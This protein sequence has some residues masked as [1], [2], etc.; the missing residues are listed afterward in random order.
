MA[1]KSVLQLNF[2]DKGT[3]C[4][5]GSSVLFEL[6]LVDNKKYTLSN[7]VDHK[8]QHFILTEWLKKHESVENEE[9][10]QNVYNEYLS[11]FKEKVENLTVDTCSLVKLPDYLKTNKTKKVKD[12]FGNVYEGYFNDEKRHGFG[13]FTK[14]D[15]YR[16]VGEWENNNKHGK[17]FMLN[18]RGESYYG[19]WVCNLPEGKGEYKYTDGSQYLG[20]FMKGE[21]EGF[22]KLTQVNG[23]IFEGFFKND[24]QDIGEVMP[25]K[26]K[27]EIDKNK[28]LLPKQKDKA[29]INPN[30]SYLIVSCG[31]GYL[32]KCSIK[33]KENVCQIRKFESKICHIAITPDQK[34]FFVSDHNRKLYKLDIRT[35][36]L[37]HQSDRK[38]ARKLLVTHDNQFLITSNPRY[39]DRNQEQNSTS[40]TKWCIKTNKKICSQSNIGKEISILSCTYDSK[41][42]LIAYIQK[43][44]SI[45]DLQKGIMLVSHNLDDTKFRTMNVSR[46]NQFAYFISQTHLVKFDLTTFE[47]VYIKD[48]GSYYEKI[49]K[50]D[51]ID[52]KYYLTSIDNDLGLFNSEIGLIVKSF[53]LFKKV[54][55]ITLTSDQ[56]NVVVADSSSNIVVI[57]LITLEKSRTIKNFDKFTNNHSILTMAI[58]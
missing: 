7:F 55:K 51:T 30:Y 16:Y 23:E 50:P 19:D 5:S 54:N 24:K 44:I 33:Q 25:N 58:V 39:S 11:S 57:D 12:T 38:T 37:I 29:K 18:K 26:M 56:K 43:Y 9:K 46:D 13:C 31:I 34:S 52:D 3:N 6:T 41:Y 40:L 4:Y 45:F 14:A 49:V 22:G 21:K 20:E 36:K 35:H 27:L 47:K 32:Y 28:A 15:D 53:G 48:S 8:I 42:L 1:N 10:Y 2:F 17:G